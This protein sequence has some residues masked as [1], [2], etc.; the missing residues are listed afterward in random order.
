MNTISNG[1]Y[2]P[3]QRLHPLN[4]LAQ[5]VSHDAEGCLQ[6]SS[7]GSTWFLHLEQG[8]L[9]YASD[10]TD[11][12]GRLDRHLRLLSIQAPSLVSA[13]RVQ[14]RLMFEEM[15][16]AEQLSPN[17]D[18][19][20][21]CW[22][23]E[24]QY[25]TP[26]Q[27]GT[28]IEAMAR[29]VIGAFLPIQMGSHALIERDLLADL[30]K[31]CWLDLCQIAEDCQTQFQR[32]QSA[33]QPVTQSA[34]QSAT[35]QPYLER[36]SDQFNSANLDRYSRPA[37]DRYLPEYQ[38]EQFLPD[39]PEDD[40]ECI[41]PQ[42]E[43]QGYVEHAEHP[44]ELVQPA[45][46]PL[47]ATH[48]L[49]TELEFPSSPAATE[50]VAPQPQDAPAAL[51]SHWPAANAIK[52]LTPQWFSDH[53]QAASKPI[54]DV[55]TKTYTIACIDDSPAVLQR[56]SSFLDDKS[57]SVVLISDPIKALMQVIRSRPDLI[58]LDVTMPN[59][60]GYELCS[61]LRKHPSFRSTPIVMVTGST[62]FIDRAKAKLVG[63]SGYL[64]KPFTQA[65][66]MKMVFKHLS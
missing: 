23:V 32:R 42:A 6:I 65:D 26:E 55:N 40:G 2:R 41:P 60:D 45:L 54:A 53:I 28:L 27:A 17:G 12:F 24:Q 58:L 29:E 34:T 13:I 4:L 33:T 1:V 36:Y 30:P 7:S 35:S 37:T 20:A 63:S 39:F 57:F 15:P 3:A 38:R 62:G 51:P 8:S 19:R 52:P 16:T 61:L 47:H 18:Y 14:V 25:L 64:T 22:L 9:V 44:A 56:I 48:E 10:L 5:Y 66:L 11:P 50:Q 59:L 49:Y 46:E 31:F 43:E 21:I